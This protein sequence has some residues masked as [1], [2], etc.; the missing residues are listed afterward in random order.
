[1]LSAE[2]TLKKIKIGSEIPMQRCTAF[3]PFPTTSK[4]AIERIFYCKRGKE[5]REEPGGKNTLA[6]KNNETQNAE[7]FMINQSS[8][9]APRFVP[10]LLTLQAI[11][12]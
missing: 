10:R 9:N 3:S 5:S 8:V 7:P 1:M 6:N 2:Y 4:M 11:L 12:S